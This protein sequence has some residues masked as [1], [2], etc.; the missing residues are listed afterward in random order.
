VVDG[1]AKKRRMIGLS[2]ILPDLISAP[3]TEAVHIA[4]DLHLSQWEEGLAE[5]R[6]LAEAA[7]AL[8]L[9]RLVAG[10]R[11]ELESARAAWRC[12][13]S[14]EI[15]RTLKQQVSDSSDEIANAVAQILETVIAEELPKT[16]LK[17][18]QA[19]IRAAFRADSAR[20]LKL[21]GPP[22]LITELT[23]A[24]KAEGIDVAAPEETSQ[25]L[26]A[27]AAGFVIVT[28]LERWLQELRRG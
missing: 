26:E 8:D 22:D 25:T 11:T 7:H 5:G 24:L 13:Q 6:R 4:G 17:S 10:H 28:M 9:A 20:D 14:E 2:R 12:D 21:R 27:S 23:R 16:A 15:A 1:I 18:I 19:E 3:I